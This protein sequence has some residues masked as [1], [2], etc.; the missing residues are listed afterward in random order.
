MTVDL[1]QFH[2]VFFEESL[3]GLDAMEACL[4]DL[5]SDNIDSEIINTIFRAAHSIKGGSA[6]FGFNIIAEFTHVLE[7]LLDETRDGS[8]GMSPTEVELYLQSVDCMRDMIN[9]LQE[10]TEP[11][12]T[13]PNKLK[14]QFEAILKGGGDGGDSGTPGATNSAE[15]AKPENAGWTIFFKP[16]T[17]VLAT[18]NDPYRMIRELATL[19][20]IKVQANIDDVP[21]VVTLHPEDCYLNWNIELRGDGIKREDIDEVFE[22]VVDDSELIIEPIA[23]EPIAI[24][25]AQE[26]SKDSAQEQVIAAAPAPVGQPAA[27]AAPAAAAKAPSKATE[28]SIRVGIDKVDDLINMVGELVITQSM[29]SQLGESFEMD[30]L[31]DLQKGIDQLQHNTRELQES[32]MRIRMLPISFVFGRFPRMVRDLS[33]KLGKQI[34]LKMI[35]ENTEMD[36]TVMEKI[37]DP[38]VH[39]VRNSIDHGIENP[40]ERIAAGKSPNGTITLNAYHQGG[41]IVIDIVDDGKGLNK[42]RILAKA[43]ENGIIA[44]DEDLSDAQINDL[45]FKPGF[46]TADVVTDVSGR[47]V[48]MDVVRRNILELNGSVKVASTPGKGSTFTITLPL[49]LAI[50]DGQLVAV[51]KQVFIF[52]LISIVESIQV[53]EDMINKVAGNADVFQL[54]DE[55]IPIVNLWDVL[56]VEGA[57][58]NLEESLLVIV[59]ANGEKVGLVVDELLGQQQFVIK[60]LETNYQRIEGVSGATILG[61]GTVALIVDIVGIAAIAGERQKEKTTMQSLTGQELKNRASAVQQ[62]H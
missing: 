36:K 41:N 40:D 38:M 31:L 29:L 42:E 52:P 4:M 1:K 51:G 8:R 37:G 57:N 24:E 48:G 46:S 60:S 56:S 15:A 14:A 10:D 2:S 18:G 16:E 23:I 19:G 58:Q 13:V 3:E 54:R 30:K 11:D 39:L 62:L 59:E 7:T 28:S 12:P 50:L 6:T 34:D 43:K 35:G 47:G 32:V 21:S 22:W 20:E 45:I 9:S 5:D 61:D 33:M 53:K 17:Q 27:V 55:Y 44:P 49:T 26:D 25:A